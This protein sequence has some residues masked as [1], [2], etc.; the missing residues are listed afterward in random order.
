MVGSQRQAT[1]SEKQ[2]EGYRRGCDNALK[3]KGQDRD[4]IGRTI[5]SD[6]T[7]QNTPGYPIEK[8][9]QAYFYAMLAAQALE[10]CID[11]SLNIEKIDPSNP[12]T[13][14]E[15]RL[16]LAQNPNTLGKRV[17]AVRDVEAEVHKL[18]PTLQPLI[19][20]RNDLAHSFV[21]EAALIIKSDFSAVQGIVND[22][23]Q[24]QEDF[25]AATKQVQLA[26]LDR[27]LEKMNL[28]PD[29]VTDYEQLKQACQ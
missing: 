2:T 18:F 13:E 24:A 8:L 14:A 19:Q 20:R 6:G 15:A 16:M 27:L 21:Y 17:Y 23:D 25:L 9:Y 12:P 22:L 7:V 10:N 11:N 4:R 3:P 26:N 28:T 5:M 1:V 29:Q